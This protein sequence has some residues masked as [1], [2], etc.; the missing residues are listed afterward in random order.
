[1]RAKSKV[2][3]KWQTVVPREIRE[4]TGISVGDTLTWRYDAGM[5]VVEP[6]KKIINPSEKLFGL[7]PSSRDAVKEVRRVRKK[8]AE[9][10]RAES[11]H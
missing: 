5:I 11:L 10:M 9:K 2:M 1:M 8:R 4:T 6:P 7:V 3:K